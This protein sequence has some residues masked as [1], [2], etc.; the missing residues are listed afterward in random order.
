MP[1]VTPL[2]LY[3][4][5]TGIVRDAITD[6]A[7][8]AQWEQPSVLE[9][10]TVG[11][12][13]GHLARTGAWILD[14]FLAADEPGGPVD[15]DD[16]ATFYVTLLPTAD[17]PIHQGIRDRGAALAAQGAQRLAAT[18]DERMPT[19]ESALRALPA[20]RKLTVTGGNVMTI[21]DYLV[22]RVV[23]QVVHLDDLARSVSRPA[24]PL[25]G[26]AHR[27][28]AAVA[29]DIALLRHE[30]EDVVR[31]LYRRGFSDAVFPAI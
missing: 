17:D 19:I 31:A 22:T 11:S 7:V 2:D 23:E 29:L 28:V 8:I 5:G 4:T 25:P 26:E 3:L 6:P 1:S 18:I 9:E 30:P 20:D 15:F 14:E 21:A 12:L 24:W 13:A 10:Q 16:V 27:L